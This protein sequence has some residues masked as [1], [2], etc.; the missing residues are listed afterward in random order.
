MTKFILV[1]GAVILGMMVSCAS[2]RLDESDARGQGYTRGVSTQRES[3]PLPLPKATTC[4]THHV[5]DS[6]TYMQCF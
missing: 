2:T 5:T 6:A 3:P 4:F 1:I